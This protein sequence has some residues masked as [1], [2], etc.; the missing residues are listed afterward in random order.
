[1]WPRKLSSGPRPLALDA[2]HGLGGC[3]VDD[4]GIAVAELDGEGGVG[5][6]HGDGLPGADAAE[7]GFLATMITARGRSA[8][9][10]IRAAKRRAQRGGSSVRPW[11]SPHSQ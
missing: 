7:G 2:T 8:A 3:P 5:D 6:Q 11:L 1:M 9:Q 10:V 4:P